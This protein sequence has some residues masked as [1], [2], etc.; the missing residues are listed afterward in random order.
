MQAGLVNSLREA[1]QPKGVVSSSNL[2]IVE[3]DQQQLAQVVRWLEGRPGQLF[4]ASNMQQ[5]LDI[6]R[7]QSIDAIITNWQLPEAVGLSLVRQF[8]KTG[9]QGPMLICADIVLSA[10]QLNLAFDVGADDYLQKPL[11]AV[12]LNVRLDASLQ[13]FDQK[14]T[15]RLFTQSQRRLVLF[16]SEHFGQELQ[17]LMRLQNQNATRE[18][19]SKDH[20]QEHLL[21]QE[22]MADFHHL[23]SWT[24]Y[25]FAL[26]GIRLRQ[27]KLKNLLTSLN[28]S[29]ADQ[30]D[31]LC[32]RGGKKLTLT[33]DADLLKRILV[34]LVDNALSYSSGTV[35]LEIKRQENA[36]RFVVRDQGKELSGGQ[37]ERL[38]SDDK[39]G[40]GLLICKDLLTLL[41]SRLEAKIDRLGG[42]LFYFDL[43]VL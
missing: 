8:R 23:M 25:R 18:V 24:R 36:L 1:D 6:L 34:Q 2:L 14:E 30:T 13:F 43:A 11:T 12:E 26:D 20:Q 28:H 37:L 29:F 5:A 21:T 9:F 17:Q 42:A 4:Q 16:L 31:R 38:M 35:T 19:L 10:E 7:K 22:I 15:L 3:A 33:S 41:N 27:F 40:L 32:F 39:S